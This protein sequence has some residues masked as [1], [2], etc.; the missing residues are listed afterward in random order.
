MRA[1]ISSRVR[2]PNHCHGVIEGKRFTVQAGYP[3]LVSA[4]LE[5]A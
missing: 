1:N 5:E 3:G 2:A 4:G